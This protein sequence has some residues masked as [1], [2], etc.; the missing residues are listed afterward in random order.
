[1]MLLNKRYTEYFKKKN[2]YHGHLYEKRYFS[3]E[4][5][6]TKGLLEVSRYIHRNP[7]ETKTP[8]VANIEDYPYSS[9][10]YYKSKLKSP[11][12]FLDTAQLPTCFKLP[13]QQTTENL[14]HFTEQEGLKTVPGTGTI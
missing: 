13:A 5:N 8:M 4:V 1:M 12:A 14:C 11:Y 6:T 9:Y 2:N 7:I 3:E 10:Q